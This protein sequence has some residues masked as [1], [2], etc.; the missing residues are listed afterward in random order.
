MGHV[1]SFGD[2]H[3]KFCLESLKGRDHLEDQDIGD[4]IIPKW[5][6]GKL[7]DAF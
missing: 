5:I 1:A 2:M 6:L 7:G 3:K 4:I